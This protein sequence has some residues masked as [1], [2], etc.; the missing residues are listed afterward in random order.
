VGVGECLGDLRGDVG[1]Q[2]D[3]QPL[4]HLGERSN[5]PRQVEAV[6]ELHG[7]VER[8]RRHPVVVG[9][10]DVRVLQQPHHLDLGGEH[11]GELG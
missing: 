6:Q 2:R 7:Q 10:D 5:Q 1:G 3:R 9:A 8:P 11:P 4:A